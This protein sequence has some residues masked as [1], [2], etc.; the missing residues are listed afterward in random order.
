MQ[1]STRDRP[2]TGE[3]FQTVS[4][5]GQHDRQGGTKAALA[6]VQKP[7]HIQVLRWDIV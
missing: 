4:G 1:Q 7:L 3:R 6:Q 5:H 2:G